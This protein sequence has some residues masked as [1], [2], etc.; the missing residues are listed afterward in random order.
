MG[1]ELIKRLG[2]D[3]Q[4]IKDKSVLD[5]FPFLFYPQY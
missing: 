3:L 1:P 2:E 4:S 5:G